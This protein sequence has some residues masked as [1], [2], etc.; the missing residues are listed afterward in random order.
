M[1]RSIRPQLPVVIM[2]GRHDQLAKLP[3]GIADA[4]L[5]KP[6]TAADLAEAVRRALGASPTNSNR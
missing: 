4:A 3:A 1:V 5:E 2:S 6:F